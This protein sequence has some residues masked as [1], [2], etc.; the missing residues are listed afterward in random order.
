MPFKK[1][2]KMKQEPLIATNQP[3]NR[4]NRGLLGVK[5]RPRLT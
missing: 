5:L 4:I 1:K 2:K 3:D